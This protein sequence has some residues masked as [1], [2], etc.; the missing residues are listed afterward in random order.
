MALSGSD[1]GDAIAKA[2]TDSS[3]SEDAK[4]AVKAVWEDIGDAICDYVV[5]NIEVQIPASKVVIA[6]TGQAAGTMNTSPIDCS[7]S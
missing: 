3:A 1:L 7:V 4:K 6:V 2:I 5:A